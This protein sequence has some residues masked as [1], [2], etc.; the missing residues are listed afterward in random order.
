MDI[1]ELTDMR[2]DPT[3]EEMWMII[4]FIQEFRLD[5]ITLALENI[6]GF[7]GLT[8]SECRGFGRVRLENQASEFSGRLRLEIA[9]PGREKAEEIIETLA[10]SAHTGRPGDGKILAWKLDRAVRIRTR[11]SGREAL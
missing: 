10:R 9:A 5:A 2:A 7:G 4:A 3:G 8:V 11:E 6:A 1:Q